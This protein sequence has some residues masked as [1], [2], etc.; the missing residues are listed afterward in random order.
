MGQKSPMNDVVLRADRQG[1]RELERDRAQRQTPSS[2]IRNRIFESSC[3][4]LVGELFTGA[5]AHALFLV[6]SR[7]A[8]VSQRSVLVGSSSVLSSS[9]AD[10]LKAVNRKK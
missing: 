6:D 3:S 8:E 5:V 9:S 7:E 10:T 1:G 4:S 2:R